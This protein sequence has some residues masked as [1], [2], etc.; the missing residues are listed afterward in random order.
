MKTGTFAPAPATT[1]KKPAAKVGPDGKQA[2]PARTAISDD[3][4]AALLAK[5]GKQWN[6]KAV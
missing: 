5:F 4:I 6:P 2:A 3:K 1:A